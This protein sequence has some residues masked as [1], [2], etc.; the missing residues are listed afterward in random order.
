YWGL[1]YLRR[2]PDEAWQGLL[3]RWLR[4][5]E[6]LG[7]VLLEDLGLEMPIRLNRPAELGSRMCLKVT[8]ADP[9]HDVIQF[10]ELT[11]SHPQP[12]LS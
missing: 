11:E 10:V 4:E 9:R 3:L 8:Y 1:E 7:L 6:N 2:N 12:A 5:H